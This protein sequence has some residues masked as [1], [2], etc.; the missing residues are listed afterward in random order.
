M[1]EETKRPPLRTRNLEEAIPT[2]QQNCCTKPT[3]N[4]TYRFTIAA[5]PETRYLTLIVAGKKIALTFILSILIGVNDIWHQ[6]NGR[7]DGTAETYRDG[8]TALLERTQKSLPSVTIVVC[9]PFVLMSGTVK[10]NKDKWFPEFDTRRKYAKQV[11]GKAGATWVPF[12]TMFDEAVA[13]GTDPSA[14]AGDGVHPTQ[15]GHALMAKTWRE[16][17]GV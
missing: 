3:R 14:L 17:V 9:E 5:S 7:Y 16:V 13:A 11:A 10:Q 6:L 8:F 1:R 4:S 2:M 12:Q 15:N